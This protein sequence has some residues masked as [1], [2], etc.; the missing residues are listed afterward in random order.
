ML[1]TLFIF[2]CLFTAHL[3][4]NFACEC[5]DRF[6]EKLLERYEQYERIV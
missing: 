6:C 3:L 4:M 5:L 2:V 1:A